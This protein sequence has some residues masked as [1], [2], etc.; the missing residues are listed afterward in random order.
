ME[1]AWRRTE[2]GEIVFEQSIPRGSR[3]IGGAMLGIFALFFLYHLISGLLEYIRGATAAEWLA[4][5]PGFLLILALFLLFGIPT[6][7][8][9]AGRTRIVL[10]LPRSRI[11]VVH[12]LRFYKRMKSFPADRAKKVTVR[13]IMKRN[14]VDTSY[15]YR[16]ELHLIDHPPI[17]I[18]SEGNKEDALKVAASLERFLKLETG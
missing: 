13:S 17:S 16:I 10:D 2:R 3:L 15:T 8:I 5:L 6:W 14:A 12:D 1:T 4:A 18:G 9:L 11:L 7:Y